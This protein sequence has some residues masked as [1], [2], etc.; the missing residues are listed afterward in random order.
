MVIKRSYLNSLPGDRLKNVLDNFSPDLIN[1]QPFTETELLNR[2]MLYTD[3]LLTHVRILTTDNVFVLGNEV[4]ALFGHLADYR[5][6]PKNRKN[7][8]D[9]YGHFR[10]INLDAFK[11]ICDKLDEYLFRYLESHYHYDYRNVNQEFLSQYTEKYFLAQKTYIDA[12]VNERTGSDRLT[13]NVINEYY[14]AAECY[15]ELFIYLQNNHSGLETT[16]WKSIFKNIFNMLVVILGIVL[17]L[18]TL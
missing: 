10:R 6:N 15:I 11:I 5:L 13:G 16:K 12:Q 2:Y 1:D 4:R 3:P 14:Q 9:A 8:S 17:S 7:L 18:L